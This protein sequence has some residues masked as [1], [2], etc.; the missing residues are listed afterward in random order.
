[1]P[2]EEVAH[3]RHGR[4]PRRRPRRFL[5]LGAVALVSIAAVAAGI[6]VTS[7]DAPT[8]IPKLRVH[9]AFATD[10]GV[11]VTLDPQ[12]LGVDGALASLGSPRHGTL[13]RVTPTTVH[14]R[15][16]PGYLGDDAFSYTLTSGSGGSATTLTG[17]VT[18]TRECRLS[19]ILVP[20]CGVWWGAAQVPGG[21]QSI[22]AFADVVEAPVPIAHLYA[23]DGEVFPSPDDRVLVEKGGPSTVLFGNIK[24]TDESGVTL[25]WAQV[26]QGDADGYLSAVAD[27]IASVPGPVFLTVHHE[28]EEEVVRTRGS[29][30]TP[31]D[32]VAMYR[33]V[34]EL[35]DASVA[36]HQVVWVWTVSGY[37][38]WES[39]WPRLYPGDDVVD[40][41]G[42]DPYLQDPAGCDFSCVVNRTYPEYPDWTGFYDWAAT[43][44][45]GKPLMLAEWA[46]RES[47]SEPGT[48][49]AAVFASA[50][51]VLPDYPLLRAIVSFNDAL[52]P[53]DPTSSRIETSQ[54]SLDA[55]RAMVASPYLASAGSDSPVPSS[56]G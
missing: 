50:P 1:M 39:L 45:S 30:W 41:V 37:P 49:K 35:V 20:T 13:E 22:A 33:H 46:V 26:A 7:D 11:T 36:P 42:Y 4:R 8:S 44:L 27:A 2:G 3:A 12:Q 17:S 15:P 38:R 16:T 21:A 9:R 19:T 47:P 18:L 31:Q 51:D 10:A 25:S 40:W 48:A 24:P 56:R 53:D 34:V 43:N 29:G 23:N 52:S 28:P 14:Y 5:L 55:F 32:Y 54:E 6:R